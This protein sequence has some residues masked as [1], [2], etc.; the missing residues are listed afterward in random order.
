MKR[1]VILAAACIFMIKS[2][3]APL[4]GQESIRFHPDPKLFLQEVK[5]LFGNRRPEEAGALLAKLETLQDKGRIEENQ[6]IDLANKA[7]KLDRLGARP[8]PHYFLFLQSFIDVN[9]FS[10]NPD[11]YR[12]WSRYLGQLLAREQKNLNPVEEFLGFTRNFIRDGIL[13]QSNTIR[14]KTRQSNAQFG[15]DSTF[16]VQINDTYLAGVGGGDSTLIKSTSGKYYPESRIWSGEGGKITWERLGIDENQVIVKINLYR[17]NL[18]QSVYS[19]DSVNLVDKRYFP[20]PLLGRVENKILLGVSPD[21]AGYPRFTSY[22]LKNRIKNLYPGLDYEGGFS[23][24]G[25]KVIGTGLPTQKSILTI[26]NGQDLFGRIASTYFSFQSDIARGLNSEVSIYIDTDSIYH[27]GLLFQ[28]S[29]ARKEVSLIRDGQGL[30]PSR[31]FNTYHDFDIDVPVIRWKQGDTVVTMSGMLGSA[32]NR[33]AFESADFF[34]MERYNEILM[35]DKKHPV[36]AV[37]QAADRMNSRTY[38]LSD[39]AGIMKKPEHLVEEMLLRL[40]FLGFVRYN[41]ETRIVEVQE[42][43]YDFLAKNSG[44]QDYDVIRFES[45]H[46]P[47]AVNAVLNLT[48]HKLTVYWVKEIE[49]SNARNVRFYPRD[50]KVEILRGRD[51]MFNGVVDAGSIRFTGEDFH[52]LY[53]D[54][55]IGSDSLSKINIRV[56]DKNKSKSGLPE[57]VDVTSVIEN[58]AGRLLIDK[59]DNKS[60]KKA[61]DHPE[62]PVFSADSVAYV[63]YD[64]KDILGGVYKRDSFFFRLDPF[65]LRGLNSPTISDTLNFPGRFVTAGIF[66]P[67]NLALSHQPDHS[68][69]FATL[70]TPE[71]GLPIYNGKGRFYKTLGMSRAGLRGAGRLDYLNSSLVSD[72]LLFLPDQVITVANSF[73][74][75]KDTVDA[76]NPQTSGQQMDVTWKPASNKLTA[77]GKDSPLSLYGDVKF[78]GEVILEPTGFSGNGIIR[79]DR[80]TISSTDF[81]FFENTFNATASEFRILKDTVM[82]LAGSEASRVTGYDA[83]GHQY[84]A[85]VDMQERTAYFEPSGS[86]SSIDFPVNQ[87]NAKPVS[88]DLNMRAHFLRMKEPE[89]RLAR[90]KTDSLII[91][92]GTADYLIP[93]KIIEAHRVEN[94][95]VADIRIFPFN[96]DITIRDAAKIDTLLNATI[97]NPDTAFHHRISQ[98]SIRILDHRTYQAKGYYQY[99]DI[100]GREFPVWFSDIRP[101]TAGISR[102]QGTLKEEDRFSLSPAFLYYGAVDWTNNEPLLHFD[103]YTQLTHTCKGITPQ[104]IR[105]ADR[106]D[107][108]SVSIPIDSVTVNQD[109]IRLFK[110]FYLSNQPIEL[111]STF[112]GPHIR[113]SDH[114]VITA[115]GRLWY[116]EP[117]G[118][119]RLT[120]AAKMASPETDGPMLVLDAIN[121]I[122]VATGKFDF[123]VDLGQVKLGGAGKMVH[124]L[125]QDSVKTNM[126]LTADFFFDPKILDYMTRSI[127]N[128]GNLEPVNY[129]S[130]EFRTSFRELLGKTKADELLD[131]LGMLGRWRKTPEEFMHT[132]VFSDLSLKWNPETGSYQSFGKLGIANI[133]GTPVNKKINGFL[134]IVHRRG[135]DSFSLYLELERQGYFFF[136]YS[137][138]LMQCLAGPKYERFNT[139]IRS[140]KESKRVQKVESGQQPYQFYPGQYRQVQ[141]FLRRFNVER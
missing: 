50:Q 134:E 131:Q 80:Y 114:P 49:L 121:C 41:S 106:I 102:G 10:A 133:N 84:N 71:E 17:L 117:S 46:A 128:A 15:V 112:V 130:P 73:M 76:G 12:S 26:F 48:N 4:S 109:K 60:G 86:G 124:N 53:N 91:R 110:G 23:L 20:E 30:S 105:F 98:S 54:F 21:Q 138:G 7:N 87:F 5:D 137:R 64:Q 38:T 42:R 29:A 94:I 120:S 43:T 62:Y 18:V 6:W 74:V 14:W 22:D 113:Y 25:K 52:F 72:N 33:A 27:P 81:R 115:E 122:T 16:F 125:M 56:F 132:L 108:D 129:A 139:M 69:G 119:Y 36:S 140:A 19:I 39:L 78:D 58:T 92:A 31:Y 32:E 8:F 96:Q 75:V 1:R 123:G 118:Q 141:E 104:W 3:I 55:A 57:P 99:R 83:A 70:E 68:L 28:Y 65:V 63:Y 24:Q 47:P 93:E 44:K 127:N 37:K 59:P 35:A 34:N 116:D 67:M 111:Y 126:I 77:R 89:M 13:F 51:M 82:Q 88:F 103:G 136:T 11:N 66:P 95:N 90:M 45:V 100:A 85:L 79:F 2:I 107:P 40:S 101:D 97:I 9:G 61:E 135:G